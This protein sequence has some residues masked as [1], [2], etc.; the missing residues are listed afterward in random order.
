MME[1]GRFSR[2]RRQRL[3]LVG[4]LIAFGPLMQLGCGGGAGEAAFVGIGNSGNHIGTD[5]LLDEVA[6]ALFA[7]E[8]TPDV[9][10]QVLREIYASVLHRAR[11][12]D[13]DAAL[14]V[15]RVAEMQRSTAAQ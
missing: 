1:T 10:D 7:L 11:E 13:P 4:L 12:G 2:Q 3:I 6:A 5:D 14:I 9:T 15:L 8:T